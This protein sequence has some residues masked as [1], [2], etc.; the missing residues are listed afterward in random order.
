LSLPRETEERLR[1]VC[2]DMLEYLNS[3][4]VVSR[5]EL[6]VKVRE[7]IRK[8]GLSD[9]EARTIKNQFD[10][11][12]D[13]LIVIGIIGDTPYIMGCPFLHEE[14]EFKGKLFYHS[15]TYPAKEPDFEAAI[16]R[17]R[18]L[19][20]EQ[21]IKS[22]E[23]MLSKAGYSKTSADLNVGLRT[24][25]KK[26]GSSITCTFFESVI[27]LQSSLDKLPEGSIIA[28]PNE[29]SPGPFISFYRNS[30]SK[31]GE[32][33]L[34]IIVVNIQDEKVSPFIG[35]PPDKD[36]VSLFTEPDLATRITTV[37]GNEDDDWE[38]LL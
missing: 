14:D 37:W 27:D 29:E 32:K 30:R 23:G 9:E 22:V 6:F 12:P 34:S 20:I 31:V 15:H 26:G 4:K 28:V 7:S 38:Q 25:R 36:L 35:Y 24:Y 16:S 18:K 17:L 33:H 1:R 19:R 21:T 10:L 3:V 2:A 5:L 11:R 8:A 13:Q